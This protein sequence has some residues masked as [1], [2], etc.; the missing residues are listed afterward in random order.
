LDTDATNRQLPAYL[1]QRDKQ[2]ILHPI[3]YWSRQLSPTE[4]R[5]PITEK[6]A[7]AVFWAV[8]LLRP[9]LEGNSFIVPT[10]HCGLIWLFNA[11][12]TSTPRLTRWRSGLAQFDFLVKYHPGVQHQTPDGISRLVTVGHDNSA[13]ENEIPCCV[14]AE[15]ITKESVPV[16][17]PTLEDSIL[18]PI[19]LYE[20]IDAQAQD[21]FCLLKFS[22]LDR[23]KNHNFKTNGKGLLVRLSSLDDAEQVM[24]SPF[25]AN[26]VMFLAHLPCIGAQLGGTRMYATLRKSFYWVAMAKDV[27]QFVAKCPSCTKSRLKRHNRTS[28]LKLFPPSSPLEFISLD[29]LG[30]LPVTKSINKHLV[31]F[32]DPYAKVVRAV[33]V[34]DI[35]T[36]KLARVF[37][38]GWVAVYGIPLFLFTDNSAQ[39]VSKLF[40]TIYRLLGVKQL[41]TTAYHPSINGQV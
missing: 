17:C 20:M 28:Y 7:H 5:Y 11:D 33:P 26:C 10:D 18:E 36:E 4:C 2:G 39:F 27:Y 14:V 15:G 21:P 16:P 41:F 37:V 1:Q 23:A 8:K 22:E 25:L 30:P 29:I 38:L 35:C 31:V 9:Y 40:Q 3:G 6:E 24:V 19:T 12:G 13:V 34:S 32:G